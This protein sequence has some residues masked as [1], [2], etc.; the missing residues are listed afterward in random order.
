M[1]CGGDHA[2]SGGADGWAEV[3]AGS[4]VMAGQY[5]GSG[6]GSRQV[7]ISTA[8]SL[9]RHDLQCVAHEGFHKQQPEPDA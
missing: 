2:Q 1:L 8:D 5:A 7:W 6:H 3:R 4:T 9:V